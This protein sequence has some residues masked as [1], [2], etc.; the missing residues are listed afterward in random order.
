MIYL[1]DDID[2]ALVMIKRFKKYIVVGNDYDS[3][4]SFRSKDDYNGK[5]VITTVKRNRIIEYAD[6]YIEVQSGITFQK[7]NNF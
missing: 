2:K 4:S 3:I 7:L 1:P 5:N 6:E